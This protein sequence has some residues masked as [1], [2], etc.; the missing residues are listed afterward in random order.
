M[1]VEKSE[2]QKL[3][4]EHPLFD[5]VFARFG[6]NCSRSHMFP[7]EYHGCENMGGGTHTVK[8]KEGA[9]H[10][11]DLCCAHIFFPQAL[12]IRD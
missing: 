10:S 12:R 6:E 3:T 5:H 1:S 4:G 8:K 7:L 9:R 2:S 11:N